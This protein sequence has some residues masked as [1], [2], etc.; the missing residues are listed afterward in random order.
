MNVDDLAK[1]VGVSRTAIYLYLNDP[2]STRLGRR[3]KDAIEEA[4]AAEQVYLDVKGQSLRRGS[5]NTIVAVI[6]MD[7]PFFRAE[8]ISQTLAGVE[9][10][11]TKGNYKLA[12]VPAA[13][14]TVSDIIKEQLHSNFGHTG[15]LLYGTRSSTLEELQAAAEL[16]LAE[17][18]PAVTLNVPELPIA[19]NQVV[20]VGTWML[21]PTEYLL[22]QGHEQIALIAGTPEAP[23]TKAEISDYERQLSAG[24]VPV[25]RDLVI[26]GRYE[27]HIARAEVEKLLSSKGPTFTA[28]YCL[29]D[30]MAL[31][32]YEALQEHGLSVPQDVSVVGKDDSFFASAMSPPLTT[33]RAPLY[34]AGVRAADLLIRSAERGETG[35]KIYLYNDLIVRRSVSPSF[36]GGQPT[37]KARGAAV[38]AERTKE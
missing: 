4:I 14:G 20:N 36:R 17:G 35:Q 23:D 2:G 28:C 12:F 33:V 8:L 19:V 26:Y 24:G 7:E 22:Q 18:A 13:G 9:D 31:G 37:P 38:Y 27:R 3:T 15:F 25:D 1:K 16:L 11:L 21:G 30:K 29:S 10:E 34:E 5:T 6:Q 32:V